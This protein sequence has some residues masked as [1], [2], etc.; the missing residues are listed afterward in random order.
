MGDIFTVLATALVIIE[1]QSLR[2]LLRHGMKATMKLNEA[3][4]EQQID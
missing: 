2:I 4:N 1:L 3:I